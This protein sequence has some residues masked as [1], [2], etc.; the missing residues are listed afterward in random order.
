[1]TENTKKEIIKSHVYGM[2]DEAIAEIYGI[3]VE[4]VRM[5]LCER[6]EDVEAEKAYRKKLGGGRICIKAL[7]YHSITAMWI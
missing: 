7:I 1:M 3:T 6:H 2:S 4:E 5:L